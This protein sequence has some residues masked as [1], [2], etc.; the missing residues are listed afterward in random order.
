SVKEAAM[1]AGPPKAMHTHDFD[2]RVLVLDG[3]IT[4]DREDGATTYR[5]GDAYSV[6]AATPHTETVGPSGVSY[7]AGRR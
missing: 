3:E 7:L 2:A 4:N 1:E 5:A 6:P